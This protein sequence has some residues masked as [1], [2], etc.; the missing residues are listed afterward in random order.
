MKKLLSLLVVIC[1]VC[2]VVS[3]S[4]FAEDAD[5][6]IFEFE[7]GTWAENAKFGTD[8]APDGTKFLKYFG[9]AP[10]EQVDITGYLLASFL[11]TNIYGF[12]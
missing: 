12:G 2:S 8:N 1:T 6:Y 3:F 4:A 10:A 11:F 5:A 9:T 7:K